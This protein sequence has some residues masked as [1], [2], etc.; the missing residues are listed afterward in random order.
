[1]VYSYSGREDTSYIVQELVGI[2]IQI[3]FF[4]P[5]TA[6]AQPRLLRGFEKI[7]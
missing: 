1:M 7:I 2:V 5:L 6:F 3:I 4:A